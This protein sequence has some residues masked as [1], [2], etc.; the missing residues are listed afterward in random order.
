[1]FDTRLIKLVSVELFPLGRSLLFLPFFVLFP[2]FLER[3][4]RFF[5]ERLV[6]FFFVFFIL[7]FTRYSSYF[8]VLFSAASF[9][10]YFC[11]YPLILSMSFFTA[12]YTFITSS[13]LSTS[14]S[15]SRTFSAN[16]KNS[17]QV[18][19]SAHARTI[20]IIEIIV[21]INILVLF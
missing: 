14:L 21:F 6:L 7:F 4:V 12:F 13:F 20:K 1:M 9:F 8:I 18:S 3:L 15:S 10:F 5:V 2:F 11:I 19:L 16:L 17:Y